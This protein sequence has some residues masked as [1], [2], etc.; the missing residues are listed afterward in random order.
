VTS[1]RPGRFASL[2]AGLALVAA[3]VLAA[4]PRP[5]LGQAPAEPDKKQEAPA[6]K[7][8]P[9]K[10]EVKPPAAEPAGQ[11]AEI[12]KQIAE[13]SKKLQELKA[14]KAPAATDEAKRKLA[15]EMVKALAWR[16]IGPANMG[17]RIISLAVVESD[18]TTYYA[19]TASGG[20]LKTTNAGVT[21]EHLFDRQDTVSIGDV[22]VA[23]SDKNIVWVG[24]G[25][26]NARNS[27]SYGDGVYKSTDAGKTW[28]NMGLKGS[29]QIGKILIHP[30]DPNVVYVGAL[31]RLFGPSAERGLFRTADGGKT[32]EKVL[33]VDEN[34]G[35]IDARM[36]PT[37]P[38]TLIVATYERKRGLYDEGDPIVRY[39]AGS[40][41]HRTT[42]GGKTWTKL[43]KGLPTVKLGRIGL[44]WYR[45]GP[46]VVFAII[47]T[48]KIGTGPAPAPGSGTPYM[49]IQGEDA[50]D[51]ARITEVTE[52]GPSE[53]AGIK[54]GDLITSFA[55]KEVK[56]YQDLVARIREGK[57]GDKVKVKLQREG[58][59]VEIELT[60][61]ARPAGMEG[62]S[63]G[64][65]G[66]PF[67]SG[68]GGQ[69]ENAQD[70]QG[71]DGFQTGGIFR[72]ADGG[73]TWTRINSLNPRP[74]YFSQVRVDPNDDQKLYVLGIAQYRS[75]DG[76]KTFRPD[77]G[78]NVHA[79]GHALWI[80]P[81]D[82][83]HMILGCD[84]GIY[85]TYD[86][87]DNWDH[88]NH[89]ALGQFY[90]VALDTRRD[91]YVYGGLQDNGTWGGPT[92]TR[93]PGGPVNEDWLSVGGGDGFQCQVDPADP[94]VVYATS[95]Y[96]AMFRRNL[97]TGEYARIRPER[98][99]GLTFKWNWNTPFILSPH[100]PR[101]FTCAANYVFRSLDRGGNLRRISP[102]VTASDEGSATALAE[103]PR[104]PD[105]LYVGTDDGKLWITRNG[106]KDWT[107]LSAKLGVPKPS[108]VGSIEASRYAEGRAYV[109]L[110]GRRS[111][112]DEP[113]LYVTEDFGQTW[114]RLGEKDVKGVTHA[115]R[116]DLANEDLLFAGGEFAPWVSL[117][118][119]QSWHSLRGTNLP[120]VAVHDFALHPTS[121]EV[122]AATHGR[123]LW[124]L[125][126]SGLRQVKG[127]VLAAPAALFQP[128]PAIRWVTQPAR[129]RTNRRYA[130]E[131]PSPGAAISY[132]L[133][134]P[135]ENVS[136]KV[137]DAEGKTIRQLRVPSRNAGLHSTTWDLTRTVEVAG[138]PG[139]SGGGGEGRGGGEARSE[140]G[141]ARPTA[142]TPAA[143]S[144]PA[145]AAGAGSGSGTSVGAAVAG[146]VQRQM[147]TGRPGLPVAPGSYRLVLAVDGKEYSKL[148]RVEPDPA[149]PL[150]AGAEAQ[151]YDEEDLEILGL[152]DPADEAERELE[153]A[154]RGREGDR[155]R[156]E[157]EEGGID[158]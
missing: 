66:R 85:V 22:A 126:V 13:L 141:E 103:S 123:S 78:R 92:R 80:N 104:N 131:N 121:G 10:E 7:P 105:V 100:N 43:G 127:E 16:P 111:D 124:I 1:H 52:G 94:D 145:P 109:A 2:A 84:G 51:R 65:P 45:K 142:A 157:E 139:G 82:G 95:Q 28:T 156:D 25:E 55:D 96:G 29:Y 17:G 119:G 88:L 21:F 108:H 73:E 9:T 3:A 102:K 32:W 158:H 60:F 107:D 138:R 56:S 26:N 86:R 153:E 39:G 40:G 6:P 146:M 93:S 152:L 27:V 110:N 35:V 81:N 20:L 59:P 143:G 77:A 72:S 125:D 116:E 46:K 136:L 99:Q 23:P 18:P 140:S 61:A 5:T 120:T 133:T 11:I 79:D 101:I 67:G 130:G 44:D 147:L 113:L 70:R 58:K 15:A 37:E 155:D 14:P 38:D 144:A 36:H 128:V 33:F 151:A 150:P 34:T 118:R 98:E 57:V 75:N 30:K 149:V 76:G 115:L 134:K 154:L 114:K 47:E 4:P 90:D 112:V 122:V 148:V 62:G 8:E 132:A 53:K 89:L 42:D 71:P 83:R 41:L 64:E 68:L 49:G 69:R 74:F 24:T 91:Y 106:G 63:G 135:A 50:E 97:K 129:G 54:G 12:E 117:D 48:E 31:G 137:V 19:A 87:M